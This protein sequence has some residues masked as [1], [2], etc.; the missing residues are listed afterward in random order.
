MQYTKANEKVLQSSS[1]VA[2]SNEQ[3]TVQS[4][5]KFIKH[6]GIHPQILNGFVEKLN[7]SKS[8]IGKKTLFF[9]SVM[10]F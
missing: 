9:S 10:F 8:K 1:L 7:D 4:V 6:N 3:F 2:W 5:G